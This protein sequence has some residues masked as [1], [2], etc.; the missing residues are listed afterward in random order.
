MLTV[1]GLPVLV[2]AN[3]SERIRPV[4]YINYLHT[5]TGQINKMAHYCRE[6]EAEAYNVNPAYLEVIK[7][8]LGECSC[9]ATTLGELLVILETMKHLYGA[10]LEIWAGTQN[11]IGKMTGVYYHPGMGKQLNL[12][13]EA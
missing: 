2:D 10:D 8:T 4:K 12:L 11:L 6:H 5:G 9:P 3:Q 13:T 1:N 7:S